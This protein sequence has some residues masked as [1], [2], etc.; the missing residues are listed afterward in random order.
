MSQE[1]R[2][3]SESI[4]AIGTGL[5][6]KAKKLRDKLDADYKKADQMLDQVQESVA[7]PLSEVVAELGLILATTS[8]NPPKS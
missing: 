5:R 1:I 2:E 6:E 8:N 7:E 4:K 3:V